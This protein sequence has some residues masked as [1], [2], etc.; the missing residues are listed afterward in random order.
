MALGAK[1]SD[2]MKLVVRQGLTLSLIGVVIGVV[3]SL[4][5]TRVMSTFL[6]GVDALDPTVFGGVAIIL[7]GVS[8]LASYIPALRATRVDPVTAL[9]FE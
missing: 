3:A 7:A 1:S 6:V 2:A 9:R 5:I 4:A 8:A